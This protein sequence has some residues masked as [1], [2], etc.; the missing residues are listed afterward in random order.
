MAASEGA[1]VTLGR[2]LRDYVE[3]RA[4][5]L[6]VAR[7]TLDI[8]DLD[9][10]A[11]IFIVDHPAARARDL[12]DY[13]GLSSAGTTTLTDRLVSRG[14]VVRQPDEVDRRVVRLTATID[15]TEEPWSALTGFD[16]A[17]GDAV[18]AGDETA[19]AAAAD[20]IAGFTR[21]ASS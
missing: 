4:A 16:T 17:F 7:K 11:L 5:A 14:V 15:L 13:L 18:D 9:A 3:A 20:L 2:A 19:A 6:L 21:T 12:G 1:R 8:G 10:R